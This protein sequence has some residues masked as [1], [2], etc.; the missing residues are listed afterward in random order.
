M[1]C[2][3]TKVSSRCQHPSAGQCRSHHC[4]PL[5][6]I[7]FPFVTLW[8]SLWRGGPAELVSTWN[9]N[10][11]HWKSKAESAVNLNCSTKIHLSH[12][13]LIHYD[14]H[15]VYSSHHAQHFCSKCLLVFSCATIFDVQDYKVASRAISS[16][17]AKGLLNI[18]ASWRPQS[19]ASLTPKHIF[20]F[21][22]P[23]PAII[24]H[25]CTTVQ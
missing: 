12:Y 25:G 14:A 7:L 5:F 18:D 9:W 10:E 3:E 20:F 16:H 15:L 8:A 24:T 6:R 13:E 11:F 22:H 4:P 2:W 19:C 1:W 17:L 21:T 23:N